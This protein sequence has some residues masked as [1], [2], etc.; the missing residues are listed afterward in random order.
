[1]TELIVQQFVNWL[2][3]ACILTLLSIGYSMLFGVLDV[4]HFSHGDVAFLTPFIAL[5]LFGTLTTG[6]T[7]GTALWPT[8]GC[9]FGSLVGVGIIGALIYLV[10]IRPFQARD[11]LIVLVATVSLGLA[12]RQSVRHIVPQGQTAH[13]FPSL[14]ETTLFNIAGVNIKIFLVV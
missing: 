7:V 2:M 6:A 1:M 14:L 4:L 5:A 11:E 8:L 9:V 13:A 12:I 3:I 10:I